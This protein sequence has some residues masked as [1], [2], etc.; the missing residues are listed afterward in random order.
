MQVKSRRGALERPVS[1]FMDHLQDSPN[2]DKGLM[3]SCSR[4]TSR[5]TVSKRIQENA[6]V[7]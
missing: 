3:N 2:Y 4:W 5:R 6:H 7:Y 1:E